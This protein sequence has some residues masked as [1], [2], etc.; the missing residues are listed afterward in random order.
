MHVQLDF[1]AV[2][3]GH[4]PLE[5]ARAGGWVDGSRV[6]ARYMDDVDRVNN[7]PLVGIGL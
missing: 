5:I 6:L 3:T 4:D 2:A 7:S 1:L